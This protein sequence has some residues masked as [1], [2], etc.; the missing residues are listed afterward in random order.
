MFWNN[1]FICKDLIIHCADIYRNVIETIVIFC[2]DTLLTD[3]AVCSSATACT[4]CNPGT[5]LDGDVCNG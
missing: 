5:Y 2:S 1:V 3:C 4:K